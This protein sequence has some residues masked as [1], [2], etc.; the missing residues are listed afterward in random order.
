MIR[1]LVTFGTPQYLHRQYLLGASATHAGAVGSHLHF[2]PGALRKEG[3]HRLFPNIRFSERGA[4]FWAWKPFVIHLALRDL[5]HGEAVIYCD[6]G[7][8]LPLKI[9]DTKLAVLLQWMADRKQDVL[10]GIKIPWHGPMSRWTKRDAFHFTGRDE[11][12]F[13]DAV[14]VQASFSIWRKT[15]ASEKLLSQWLEWCRDRR[16]ISDDPSTCGLPE[17]PDFK[18]HRH[19][20]SLLGLLCTSESLNALDLGPTAPQFDEKNP[21]AV[22]RFLG[23]HPEK[24]PFWITMMRQSLEALERKIRRQRQ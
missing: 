17:L 18:E 15:P 12:R 3:F 8:T 24:M 10:P 5:D 1:R 23:A 9:I 6:V 14:Q 19:D 2:S 20:Q 4:G 7:R 13:H 11:S 16:L 22:A 21:A